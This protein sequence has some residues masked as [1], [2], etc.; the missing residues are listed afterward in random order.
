MRCDQIQKYMTVESTNL[1][2]NGDKK[3]KVKRE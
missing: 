2:R 3:E 1:E